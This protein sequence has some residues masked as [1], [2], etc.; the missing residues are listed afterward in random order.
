MIHQESSFKVTRPHRAELKPCGPKE[1]T[2]CVCCVWWAVQILTS[3]SIFLPGPHR[4][5]SGRCWLDGSMMKWG[6]IC[7][8]ER[9]NPTVSYEQFLSDLG[10]PTQSAHK[11]WFMGTCTRCR[12]HICCWG[13]GVFAGVNAGRSNV[14]S[15]W[16][17]RRGCDSCSGC[18]G[19]TSPVRTV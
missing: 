18:V 17:H 11:A 13:G 19:V 9:Q 6:E 15:L 10:G 5:Y 3:K 1:T 14:A 2:S 8:S 7:S 4:E 12:S 16:I